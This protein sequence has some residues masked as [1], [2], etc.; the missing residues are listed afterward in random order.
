MTTLLLFSLPWGYLIAALFLL[1]AIVLFIV[2]IF[3]KDTGGNYEGESEDDRYGKQEEVYENTSYEDTFDRYQNVTDAEDAEGSLQDMIADTSENLAET[4][5]FTPVVD[6]PE[7]EPYEEPITVEEINEEEA[8]EEV[9]TAPVS[10]FEAFA[11]PEES[12]NAEIEDEDADVKKVEEVPEAVETDEFEEVVPPKKALFGRAA[13]TENE[14]DDVPKPTAN[15][16]SGM[17][18]AEEVRR[19]IEEEERRNKN[20]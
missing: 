13:A 3:M 16:K 18:F 9:Y 12:V 1:I 10:A 20:S 14:E 15:K 7:P 11:E 8:P 6:I 4:K 17:S 2:A 19:L 5:M